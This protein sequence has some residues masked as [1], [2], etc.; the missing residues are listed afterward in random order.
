MRNF[1]QEYIGEAYILSSI[2]HYITPKIELR[3]EILPISDLSKKNTNA[4]I[5]LN[6]F[7]SFLYLRLIYGSQKTF[8]TPGSKPLP[9]SAMM[10]RFLKRSW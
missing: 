3:T 1:H 6:G 4:I 8:V 5:K 10:P 7:K 2:N 9:S